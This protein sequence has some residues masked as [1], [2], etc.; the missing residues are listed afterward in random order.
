MDDNLG[1]GHNIPLLSG[2][3]YHAVSGHLVVRMQ[4]AVPVDVILVNPPAQ[5]VREAR[6]DTPSFPAIGI[7]Y[8]A[9]Y[10]EVHGGI[11]PLV[12]DARLERRTEAEVIDQIVALRPRIVGFSAMT[13]MVITAARM[14]AAIKARSPETIA[15]LG[16][17]HATFLPARTLREFPIF[18]FIVVGEGEIAFLKLAQAIMSGEPIPPI[19]GVWY[20]R[21]GECVEAGRGEIPPSLDELGDPGWHLFDPEAMAKYCTLVPIMA[22]RGCPFSCNF[23]S[24]PYGQKVRRRTAQYVVDEMEAAQDKFGVHKFLFFDETFTVNKKF[25]LEICDEIV[26]RKLDVTWWAHAHANTLD[27]ELVRAMKRAG[28]Y[29]VGMGVESGNDDIMAAMKKGITK[30]SLIRAVA[31]LKEGGLPGS[32]NIIIGHPNETMKT[33]W[34]SIRFLAQLNPIEPVIGIMVPYPGTEIWELA[35]RGEGGY[36][37]MSDNW[38]DYNKQIGNA[39]SMKSMSRRTMEL[40]QAIGYVYIFLRNGRIADMFRTILKNKTLT[41]NLMRR[42]LRL[43]QIAAPAPR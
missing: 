33:A 21:D 13:H 31:A 16:G 18:D 22:Q 42:L 35:V 36:V 24:R 2:I 7:A 17:F 43:P 14:A 3:S 28:C 29:E 15:V 30:A 9:N 11:T 38:D 34:Q 6:Y 32:A 1:Y 19:A 40:M 20:I 26:R 39:V 23:C 10:L 37:K 8:I 4:H 25:T 41:V 5:V 27:V 12:I